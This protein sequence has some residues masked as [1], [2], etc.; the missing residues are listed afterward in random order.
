MPAVLGYWNLRGL[1]QPIRL[2]L[3]YTGEEYEEK[4]YEMGP[5]PEY[6]RE[7]WLTDKTKLGVPFAN[8]PYYKDGDTIIVQ[9]RAI[10]MHLAR[11]HNLYGSTEAEKIKADEI[12]S[13]VLDTLMSFIQVCLATYFYKTDYKTK[14]E[15][16]LKGLPNILKSYS[17]FL[18]DN[19]WVGG[20]NITYA[21][22]NLYELLDW[23]RMFSPGCLDQ[24]SNLAG[25]CKNFEALPAIKKYMAS[26]QFI[27]NPV[28]GPFA[29]WGA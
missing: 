4:R 20:K 10:M 26:A 15:E 28:F 22:F 17:D 1:G 2:M 23:F 9:S 3:A 13:Q 7:Q 24:F 8:I 18:G 29:D 6:S 14:K 11:K 25:Y 5:A 19:S 21:D 16:F 12:A 27:K